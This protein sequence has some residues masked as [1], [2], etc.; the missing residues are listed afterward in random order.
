MPKPAVTVLLMAAALATAGCGYH[1]AGRA[2]NVPKTVRTIYLPVFR[3][4]TP[5]FKVEQAL[6]SAVAREFLARTRYR[7]ARDEPSSDAVLH[8]VVTGYWA[9]PV[10]FDPRSNRATTISVNVRMRAWLVDRK[11]GKTIWENLD[12]NYNERYEISQET[13]GYFEESAAAI[14]RL[15][16]SLAASLVANILEGF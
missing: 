8:G 7:I 13:A 5:R 15:S 16:R 14:E 6:T 1:I 4:E 12:Y 2:D 3:N 9:Y 10:V 11:T